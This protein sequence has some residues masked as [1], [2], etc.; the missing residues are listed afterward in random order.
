MSSCWTR[1]PPGSARPPHAW[2]ACGGT[3]ELERKEAEL[4]EL[5][6]KAG[7]ADFWNDPA[8]AQKALQRR[9]RLGEEIAQGRKLMARLEEAQ[10]MLD[11]AR[12]GEE[13][14]ADL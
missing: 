13:V 14:E 7:A 11:L 4:T 10:V 12:E 6:E 1:S 9:T 5:E 3:F 2:M 8:A